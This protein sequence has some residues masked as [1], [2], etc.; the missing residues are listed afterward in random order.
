MQ[1]SSPLAPAS[2]VF[3]IGEALGTVGMPTVTNI[4]RK[5]L[6]S[7]RGGYARRFALTP[8]R[9][10]ASILRGVCRPKS[11]VSRSSPLAQPA[12]VAADGTSRGPCCPATAG[13]TQPFP[14]LRSYEGRRGRHTTAGAS[15]VFAGTRALDESPSAT[16][17]R[18]RLWDRDNRAGSRRRSK[19]RVLAV[20][21]VAA[22]GQSSDATTL[23]AVA[24]FT[25]MQPR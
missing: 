6:L 2:P 16:A 17:C 22:P 4:A 25:H 9:S 15:L 18:G 12:P 21:G 24:A 7:L 5:H 19:R 14:G 13:R 20:A 23:L 8:T 3:A 10:P 1:V 11:K